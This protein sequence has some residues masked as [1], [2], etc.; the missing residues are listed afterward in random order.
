MD[1]DT[2]CKWH[3]SCG[4]DFCHGEGVCQD[5]MKAKR[6]K[7]M[8]LS[9]EELEKEVDE[10]MKEEILALKPGRGLD[11]LVA[12]KVFGWRRIEGPHY[13]Y[14]GPCE[15]GDVLIP[16]HITEAEAYSMMSP[17]GRIP[18]GYFVH[19]KYSS[20]ISAAWEVIDKLLDEGIYPNIQCLGN[21]VSIYITGEK[22]NR[23]KLL[24]SAYGDTMPEAICKAALLIKQ[25]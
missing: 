23:I 16:P 25:A 17:R 10:M 1:Y 22:P 19:K 11:A 24:A 14:D 18:L 15:H 3:K 6:S 13:D 5:F 8:K 4:A 20:H 2:N 7:G 21:I 9:E 12:E